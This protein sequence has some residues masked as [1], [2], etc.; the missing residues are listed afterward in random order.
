M[1]ADADSAVV[2][3]IIFI[4]S[5][6]SGSGKSSVCKAVMERRKNLGF[7]VS[8]TTRAPRPGEKD[9]ADYYFITPEEF[10]TRVKNGDF[11]ESA[12]VHG[13]KYGTLRKEL[14]DKISRGLDVLVDIDVQGAM[15]IKKRAE[16]DRLLRDSA[17]YIFIGPPSMGELERRLRSRNT[18]KESDVEKRLG[19][20]AR[21][22]SRWREY[23]YLLINDNLEKAVD[24]MTALVD[25]AHIK[26]RHPGK[27]SSLYV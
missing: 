23:D 15:Q 10:E 3:G 6:P 7:S 24:Q 25:L 5:G 17:E 19:N 27:R 16:T 2:P 9:G 18:E 4:V 20:A 21:E 26:T 22:I 14:T 12:D 8:C 11:A 13:N 1:G